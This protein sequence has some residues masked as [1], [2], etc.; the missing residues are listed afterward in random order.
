[1]KMFIPRR[2]RRSRRY[3]PNNSW[4]PKRLARAGEK[5]VLL[6]YSNAYGEASTFARRRELADVRRRYVVG[7]D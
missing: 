3:S 1:M 2:S 5:Y 7:R 4:L 6:T